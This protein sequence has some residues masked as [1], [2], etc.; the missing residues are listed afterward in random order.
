MALVPVEI[1]NAQDQTV[2]LSLEKDGE[3]IEYLEARVRRGD[4]K[5]VKVLPAPAARKAAAK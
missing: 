3:E 5:S 1:V 4:L 2:R